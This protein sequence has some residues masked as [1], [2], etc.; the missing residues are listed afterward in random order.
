MPVEHVVF[1]KLQRP[2]TEVERAQIG[3]CISLPDVLNVSCGPTYSERGG[4][5]NYALVLTFR[6]KE[7]EEQFRVHPLHKLLGSEII[8]PLMCS[9]QPSIAIDY[10]HTA[11]VQSRGVAS[12]GMEANAPASSESAS[13]APTRAPCGPPLT[14]AARLRSVLAATRRAGACELIPACHDALSATLIANAGFQVAFMSG[15]AVSA[16]SIALPDVGLLSYGEQL[17]VGRAI[18]EATRGRLAVIGDGDTGFG[19]SSNVRRAVRGYAA[20]GF[21][22]ISIEDQVRG[23]ATANLRLPACTFL[24]TYP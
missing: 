5:F 12:G 24:P 23:L 13:N 7:A 16:T 22:A 19:G 17:G 3:T 21:A 15:F 14:P 18:C 6:S 11:T 10:E 9:E 2:L 4:G 8:G 1:L 20:A